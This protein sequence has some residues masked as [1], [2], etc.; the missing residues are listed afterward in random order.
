MKVESASGRL[1]DNITGA[2]GCGVELLPPNPSPMK[3]TEHFSMTT[4][5]TILFSFAHPDDESFLVAGI[6]C[7]YAEEGARLALV[8]ATRGEQGKLGEAPNKVTRAELPQVRERETRE[9]ARI[10]GIDDVRFLGYEDSKLADAPPDEVRAGLVR[11]I[12]DVRP[13][14]VVTFDPNGGNNHADHVAISRFTSEAVAAAADD[15]WHATEGAPHKV[16]RLVWSLPHAVWEV[17]RVEEPEALP[18]VDLLF[19][20]NRWWQRK[21]EALRAH[22]SQKEGIDELFFDVDD[23]QRIL[24]LEAFRLGWEGS[25]EG[26]PLDDLFAGMKGR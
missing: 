25:P 3:L 2:A 21:A 12:R 6:A 15:R 7:R 8:V 26:R 13:Q 11:V 14:V 4:R 1:Q 16:E 22:R 10:I 23:T 17:A 24:S 9:A 5:R 20:T 19:D 18:G